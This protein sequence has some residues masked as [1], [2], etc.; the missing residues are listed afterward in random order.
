MS[1]EVNDLLHSI[2]GTLGATG[3]TFSMPIHN[4]KAVIINASLTVFFFICMYKTV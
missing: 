4:L 3:H 1:A 2:F